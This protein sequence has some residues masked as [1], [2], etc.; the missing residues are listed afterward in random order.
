MVLVAWTVLILTLAMCGTVAAQGPTWFMTG[1]PML[2]HVK[3]KVCD[4]PRLKDLDVCNT[5]FEPGTLEP[6]T[7]VQELPD[8]VT[9]CAD[10]VGVIVLDGASRGDVGCVA[11][12]NLTGVN[13]K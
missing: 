4:N 13:P 1:R 2:W 9:P 8:S 11:A 12:E 5:A 10:L 3:L 6:G 7:R